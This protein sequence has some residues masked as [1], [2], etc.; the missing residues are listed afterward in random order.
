MQSPPVLRPVQST[1]IVLPGHS[2]SLSSVL[3]VPISITDFSPSLPYPTPTPTLPYYSTLLLYPTGPI[4]PYPTQ[5]DQPTRQASTPPTTNPLPT[6]CLLLSSTLPPSPHPIP[7]DSPTAAGVYSHP[8]LPIDLLLHSCAALHWL[9]AGWP[10]RETR[11]RDGEERRQKQKLTD[12][13]DFF[14][15]PPSVCPSSV[16]LSPVS[17]YSPLLSLVCLVCLVSPDCLLAST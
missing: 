11:N 4:L 12:Q 13:L 8:R 3:A 9:L 10:R 14:F 15:T 16:R 2:S 5:L 17:R 7:A 6:T 1:L